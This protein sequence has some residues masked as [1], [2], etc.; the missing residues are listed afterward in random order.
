MNPWLQSGSII[1]SFTNPTTMLSSTNPP[2]F[3][4]AEAANP[5]GDPAAT[6]ALSI[7]PVDS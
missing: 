1:R 4:A 5:K 7:S 3:M 2:A 6:A